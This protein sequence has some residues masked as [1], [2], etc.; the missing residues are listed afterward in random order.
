[1]SVGQLIES[2]PFEIEPTENVVA[3]KHGELD[4]VALKLRAFTRPAL[5]PVIDL[6]EA[7]ER[8]GSQLNNDATNLILLLLSNAVSTPKQTVRQQ[9]IESKFV[10]RSA[11]DG[12]K[13]VQDHRFFDAVRTVKEVI[14]DAAIPV[15]FRTKFQ[16]DQRY[17]VF[18]FEDSSDAP[19]AVETLVNTGRLTH[20]DVGFLI[21][22]YDVDVNVIKTVIDKIHFH[23]KVK[24]DEVDALVNYVKKYEKIDQENPFNQGS[25]AKFYRGIYDKAFSALVSKMLPAIK[26][27]AFEYE[28]VPG[29]DIDDL[30][31]EGECG[32]L[33]ALHT[34]DS[35]LGFS[36]STTFAPIRVKGKIKDFLRQRN[37]NHGIN[38]KLSRLQSDLYDSENFDSDGASIIS[39][40]SWDKLR[41]LENSA[42]S[43]SLDENPFNDT[44]SD[45]SL[46]DFLPY[47]NSDDPSDLS[48]LNPELVGENEPLLAEIEFQITKMEPRDKIIVAFYIGATSVM[49]G[50]ERAWY[51]LH[52]HHRGAFGGLT[53]ADIGDYLDITESRVAQLM[54]I[55]ME[56]L[57]RNKDLKKLYGA[58]QKETK[59]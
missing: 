14:D 31:F 7:E 21:G 48:H 17:I 41:N 30:I 23:E 22:L 57:K 13:L 32:L 43:V 47:E 2:D 49:N 35:N 42:Y 29:V 36:F 33:D 34:Y 1:M 26:K 46:I 58:I 53:M 45:D 5:A 38:R 12:N 16:Y 24:S 50:V 4:E 56:S 18:N 20:E 3:D 9:V 54:H 19:N 52:K 11:I 39:R 37:E 15:D 55:P 8:P 40:E 10:E 59:S 6:T 25:S 44:E 27:I 28:G 51:T